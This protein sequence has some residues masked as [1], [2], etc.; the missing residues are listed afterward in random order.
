MEN[1]NNFTKFT[2]RENSIYF[3][4]LQVP[5]IS[6][7]RHIDR[8]LQNIRMIFE[9]CSK[10]CPGQKDKIPKNIICRLRFSVLLKNSLARTSYWYSI[11]SFSN[12]CSKEGWL[13]F[14]PR[15]VAYKTRKHCAETNVSK[16]SLWKHCYGN[17]LVVWKQKKYS[18]LRSKTFLCPYWLNH[19]DKQIVN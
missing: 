10:A 1:L 2:D 4:I 13:K 6:K 3:H 7:A 16:F 5:H 11:S 12:I 19:H 8:I 9:N 17:K 14:P 18:F 15:R